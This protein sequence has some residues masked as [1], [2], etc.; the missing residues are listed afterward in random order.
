MIANKDNALLDMVNWK[1]VVKQQVISSG[2][3]WLCDM[4]HH[5]ELEDSSMYF[6]WRV[7]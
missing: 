2:Y 1:K 3:D 6:G 5:L 7:E 4:D